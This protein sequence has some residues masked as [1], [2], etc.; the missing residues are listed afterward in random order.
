MGEEVGSGGRGVGRREENGPGKAF[1]EMGPP[2]L[3]VVT[4]MGVEGLWGTLTK[5]S[6]VLK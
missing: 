6:G 1:E 2:H 5:P 3:K 4:Y